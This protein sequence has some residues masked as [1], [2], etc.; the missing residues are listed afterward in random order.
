LFHQGAQEIKEHPFFAGIDW[1]KILHKEIEPPFKPHLVGAMDL[2]YFDPSV[3][4]NVPDIAGSPC[5]DTD[6]EVLLSF[7]SLPIILFPNSHTPPFLPPYIF[8]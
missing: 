5:I 7:Y 2:K 4:A 1:K 6:D 8:Y 3:T